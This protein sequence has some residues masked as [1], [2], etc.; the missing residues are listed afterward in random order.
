MRS[1]QSEAATDGKKVLPMAA[2]GRPRLALSNTASVL[3]PSS[4]TRA[5]VIALPAVSITA[6]AAWW[7]RGI[8][9]VGSFACTKP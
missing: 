5:A 3:R 2:A 6:F 8:T 9:G 4:V 7:L 1:P